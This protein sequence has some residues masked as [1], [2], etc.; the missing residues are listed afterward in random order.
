MAGI[1]RA[2]QQIFS[3]TGLTPTGG[4]GAAAAGTTTTEAGSSNS[5]ANIQ[6]GQSGVWNAGWLSAV[7]GASK[8]PAVEDMNGIFNVITNQIA[9]LLERGIPEYD[10][11]TSYNIGDVCKG[12]GSSLLY[13][14]LT[15]ANL[16]NALSSSANWLLCCDLA[17]IGIGTTQTTTGTN[18]TYAAADIGLDTLR[19]NSGA[20]MVDTLPGTSP[21]VLPAGWRG[22]ITNSDSS[23]L[24]LITVGSGANLS[25]SSSNNLLLGPG[26]HALIFS[27]GANYW[28]QE[29]GG[30]T[31]LG[32]ATNFYIATTGSDTTGNG[33]A[34][35]TPWLTIQ[36]AINYIA[37]N[38][39]F[40]GQSVTINVAT[41]T[42]TG[43]VSVTQPWVGGSSV[44][45]LGNTTT[46][47]N[48]IISTTNANCINVSGYGSSLIVEGFELTT[49][50]GGHAINVTSGGMLTVA[51]NMNFAAISGSQYAH[52]N[53]GS[54]A[55][56]YIASNYTI[57]GGDSSGYHMQCAFG[58]QINMTGVTVTVSGTPAF[59][60]FAVATALGLIE[61]TGDTFSGS[62]TGTRYVANL[63]GVINTSGGGASYFPGNAGGTTATGGQYA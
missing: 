38:I 26:Q 36:H 51:G 59:N 5:V 3:T 25:G 63:N 23:A 41:G 2:T 17:A 35:G 53:C 62:A 55:Y 15:N 37:N 34:S 18:H 30:R 20:V 42:Y 32:A 8:F 21:G 10:S 19:S 44:T 9:Y 45:L 16:G 6:T 60:T 58:G 27:D 39:D 28:V 56:I 29:G 22:L 4:F 48:C 50:T 52:L 61:A 24:L 33:I 54:E 13:K 40:N 46:P 7:L 49:A 31:R 47:T 1:A 43:S 14:S 57:S 11:G 12:I